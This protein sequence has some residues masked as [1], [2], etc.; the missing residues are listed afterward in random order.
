MPDRTLP[1]HP[2]LEQY[3]KQAKELRRSVVAGT[4]AAI[5]R[6]RQHHP[7]FAQAG[8]DSVLALSLADAQ[9]VLAREHG[10]ESWPEFAKHI[11]TLR[12]IRALGIYVIRLIPSSKS[13]ALIAMA[14]TV[15]E[16][17]NTPK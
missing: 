2:N 5:E 6:I 14:G 10:Y 12:V 7:R 4:S 16:R 8:P 9:L 11:Q 1:D 17:S 15:R 13:R 3:K